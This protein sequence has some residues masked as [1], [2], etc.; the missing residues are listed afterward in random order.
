MNN[1]EPIW[2]S[3]F[4]KNGGK[5]ILFARQQARFLTMRRIWYRKLLFEFGVF[6]GTRVKFPLV[7]CIEQ[8]GDWQL[9]GPAVLTDGGFGKRR[10]I[11]I[12]PFL[13]LLKET[14]KQTSETRHFYGQLKNYPKN[15]VK[16]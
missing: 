15:K 8:F 3:W 14:W 12:H 13:P 4:A 10:F 7:W 16:Y 11:S 9:T 1:P 6:T 2:K 5:L